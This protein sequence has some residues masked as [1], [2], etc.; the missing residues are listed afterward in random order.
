MDKSLYTFIS[1]HQQ[2]SD[3]QGVEL[4]VLSNHLQ[5]PWCSK[6]P[7]IRVKN[8]SL[9]SLPFECPYKYSQGNKSNFMPSNLV[10]AT[11]HR[12]PH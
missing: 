12:D 11:S 6:N 7:T 1:N 9:F 4:A 5:Q 10:T 8:F 3:L 2:I